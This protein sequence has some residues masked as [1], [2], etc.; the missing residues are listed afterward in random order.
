[1]TAYEDAE[2][3]GDD[4][5][6][7]VHAVRVIGKHGAE[8]RPD[9]ER[10]VQTGRGPLRRSRSSEASNVIRCAVPKM[11]VEGRFATHARVR[12]CNIIGPIVDL[13]L[14]SVN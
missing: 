3:A 6:D 8:L 7:L 1:M 14:Y 11:D 4:G 10:R 9:A 12:R 13:V 5:V 2:S